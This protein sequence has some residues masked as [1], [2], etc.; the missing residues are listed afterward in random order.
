MDTQLDKWLGLLRAGQ[1]DARDQVIK[2]SCDRV[3]KLASRMLSRYP[4][5]RRW[6]QTE[7]VMQKALMRLHH[8]LMEVHPDSVPQLLGLAARQVRWT[9]LDLVRHHYG[10]MGQGKRHFTAGGGIAADDPEGPVSRQAGPNCEPETLEAWEKFHEAAGNLPDDARQVFDLLW[11]QG[12]GQA[13]AAAVLGVTDRT[14][15]RRWETARCLLFEAMKGQ[16]PD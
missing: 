4:H 3:R 5:L 13:E 11:Y 2:Y 6:E 1:S 12:M 14:V 8:C 7:D 16:R 9:L 15:R 10:P